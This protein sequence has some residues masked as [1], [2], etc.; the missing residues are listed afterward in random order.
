VFLLY[1]LVQG[2][3]TGSPRA[4][5]GPQPT[6]IWPSK[7]ITHKIILHTSAAEESP[8]KCLIYV[9]AKN[10]QPAVIIGTSLCNDS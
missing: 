1:P 2:C 6:I 10:I 8:L 9:H 4:G 3:P 5:F 7:G